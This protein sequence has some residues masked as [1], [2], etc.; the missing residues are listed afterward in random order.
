MIDYRL[1]L[2]TT[3]AATGFFDVVPE[4][5]ETF[6]AALLELRTAPMDSFMRRRALD[7]LG[8]LGEERLTEMLVGG[9]GMVKGLIYEAALA[10]DAFH[11][12]KGR[13]ETEGWTPEKIESPLVYGRYVAA[14][15]A[16]THPWAEMLSENVDSLK[17]LP[18]FAEAPDL[19]VEPGPTG[20][21]EPLSVDE[22]AAEIRKNYP[23]LE[24]VPAA[25]TAAI[26][27]AK[28]EAIGVFT[29]SEMR[30]QAS[31]SPLALL[32]KWK[33]K[34]RVCQGDLNY[35]LSGE[36]TSY[37]KGLSIAAA[38]ASLYMEIAERHSSYAS[39]EN[40]CVTDT[41]LQHEVVK[42]RYSELAASGR[43]VLSP[44]ALMLDVPYQDDVL[45][46]MEGVTPTPGGEE[47]ILVPVQAVFLFMNLDEPGLFTSLGSTGLASGN[48]IDEARVSGLYEALEREA[49]A[50]QPFDPTLCFELFTAND[51]LGPLLA[52]YR[53]EGVN[54]FFQELTGRLGI[55]CCKAMVI[56]HEG[57]VAKGCATHLDARRAAVSAMTE[58]PFVFPG[59]EASLTPPVTP[60]P[61]HEE[62]LP[63][64]S[65]GSAPGDR[66]LVEQLLAHEGYTPIYVDL[67]RR[68]LDIPVVK[69]LVPGFAFTAD[70][71][72]FTRM[73]PKLLSCA[74]A[75]MKA[76]HC[77]L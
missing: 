65:T 36:Q 7:L 10:F 72:R 16:A 8:A 48:T 61:V 69:T 57:V 25:E 30:H 42:A 66:K 44:N 23:A 52:A 24:G 31:L 70:F 75:M 54:L 27:K 64:Y 41:L 39:I 20:P 3:T 53:K 12:L 46:W 22:M 56:D 68:D 35:T 17:E 34:T 4:G 13:L 71:D 9:D 28:L 33:V 18:F 47:A 45:H 55:P 59:G 40:G 1:T 2:K 67:T 77:K 5:V 50:T 37:G 15:G 49:E 38:R 73:S 62:Q 63:D 76:K 58:V 21:S 43:R 29:G 51:N 6:E 60:V 14:N 32:R 74:A 11:A 26:A 19:P